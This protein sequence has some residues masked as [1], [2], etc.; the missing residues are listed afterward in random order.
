[1]W[2]GMDDK[3]VGLVRPLL[4]LHLG[5]KLPT[6]E[7]GETTFHQRCIITVTCMATHVL[8]EKCQSGQIPLE[9]GWD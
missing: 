5:L 8:R 4:G 6:P 1:M 3:E 7:L 9:S 2:K